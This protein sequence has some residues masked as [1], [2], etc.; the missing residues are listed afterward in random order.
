P[1]EYEVTSDDESECDVPVKDESSSVFTTFSNPIFDCNDD[2]TSSNDESLSNKDV[3]MENFKVYSNLLFDDEE[4]NSDKID[5]HYFNVE[6][7]LIESLSNQDTLFDSFP[8]FDYLEEF[9]GE[10]MPTSIINEERIKREHE[11]YIIED[12]DSLREEIDIFTGT[13]DLMPPGIESDDDDSCWDFTLRDDIDGITISYHSLIHKGFKEL[14]VEFEGVVMCSLTGDE[15][16]G[17][18]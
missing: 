10:L 13:D 7:D 18:G 6:Y 15:Y 1:S 17:Y 16:L 8:K 5:P 12:S 4:I 9:S 11:E 3:P 14:C 2:F